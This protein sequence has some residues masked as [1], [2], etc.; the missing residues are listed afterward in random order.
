MLKKT[1]G[2]LLMQM[3][4]KELTQWMAFNALQDEEYKK[5]VERDVSLEDGALKSQEELAMDM[6]RMLMGIQN[7]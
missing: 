1:K 4:S 3:G 6:K 7:G 2:E 5:K